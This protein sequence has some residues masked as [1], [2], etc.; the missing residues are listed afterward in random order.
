MG[1]YDGYNSN[2]PVYARNGYPNTNYA[3]YSATFNAFLNDDGNI[4]KTGRDRN[5]IVGVDNAKYEE[6]L[7]TL[8]KAEEQREEFY[9]KLVE[10]GI[11]EVPKTAEQILAEQTIKFERA[12]KRLENLEKARKTTNGRN[13]NHKKTTA[14]RKAKSNDTKSTGTFGGNQ[15]QIGIS[16]ILEE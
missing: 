7:A 10:H 13:V 15:Q 6:T 8:K 2:I 4:I 12:L 14:K 1:K 5:T 11:I 3:D 16:D 9:Q